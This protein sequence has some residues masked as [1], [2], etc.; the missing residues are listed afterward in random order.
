MAGD[1]QPDELPKVTLAF[2]RRVE[3]L[4]PRRVAFEY[5]NRR[6]NR[7]GPARWRVANQITE[8][9]RLSHLELGP[10][11]AEAFTPLPDL[12]PEEREVYGA[13]ARW[14]LQLFGGRAVRSV[15][16]TDVDEWETRLS[17]EG[18]R[19]VGRAGLAVEDENGRPELRL[20]RIGG[21][22]PDGS[23]PLSSPEARFALLRAGDWLTGRSVRLVH[24]DLLYGGMVDHEVHADA[25]RAELRLWVSRR[26]EAVRRRIADPLPRPGL[27]CGRCRFVAG[28][29]AHG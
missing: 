6:G 1:E 23:D 20:L 17:D 3:E 9:A 5:H 21:P 24:A 2:L 22:A 28:C 29:K 4:C 8:H 12:L 7:V 13:A 14:Y 19:L 15:D 16:G 25:A 27:E 11:T 18:I 10:P 26:L